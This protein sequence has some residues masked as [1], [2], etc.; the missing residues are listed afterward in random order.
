[1]RNK[2]LF[3]LVLVA[4]ITFL[5]AY[6]TMFEPKPEIDPN[7][8]FETGNTS[9]IFDDLKAAHTKYSELDKVDYEA[10]EDE[11]KQLGSKLNFVNDEIKVL[12]ALLKNIESEHAQKE[13]QLRKDKTD[14]LNKKANE[15]R[16]KIADLE[17]KIDT[18]KDNVPEQEKHL[19]SSSDLIYSL[20]LKGVEH[21]TSEIVTFVGANGDKGLYTVKL[22]GYIDSL[23]EALDNITTYLA[24]YDVSIGNCSFRQVYSCYNNMRPWDRVTLLNWFENNYVTGSGSTGSVSGGFVVDGIRVS[25]VLGEDTIKIL[26]DCKLRDTEDAKLKYQ[27]LLELIEKER[28]DAIIAA[29]KGLDQSKVNSLINA[30]NEYYDEKI[31]ATQLELSATLE[32]I[33]KDYDYR[34]TSLTNPPASGDATLANP[35]ILIYTLDITFSVYDE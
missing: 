10:Q 6:M 12:K 19:V 9:T 21:T 34:I 18:E 15:L 17:G 31:A 29:Y 30:L 1:M 24:P 20:L 25:G 14:E 7:T 33:A 2:S 8:G 11:Y 27:K 4:A 35:D 28:V 13:D 32:Q 26:E 22:V 16:V 5:I 3:I 23:S